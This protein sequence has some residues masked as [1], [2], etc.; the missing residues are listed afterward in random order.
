MTADRKRCPCCGQVKPLAGF[1]RRRPG[2]PS[3]YCRV[4]Q[5][6][7]SRASRQR[8]MQDPASLARLRARDRARKRRRGGEAA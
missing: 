2:G 7:V 5:R 4:C 6:K 3:G 1:Y 8:R